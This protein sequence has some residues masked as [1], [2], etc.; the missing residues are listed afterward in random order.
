FFQMLYPARHL[1]IPGH[2]DWTG[3]GQRFAWRMKIFYKDFDM[4]FYTVTEGG[5]GQQYE[6][7]L[8]KMLTTKQ[9]TALGYYPDLIPTTARFIQAQAVQSGL[10]NPIVR[11]DFQSGL[12][13]GPMQYL[14]DPKADATQL[15]VGFFGGVDW[16][17]PYKGE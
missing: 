7:T 10:P 11:V 2:V 6:T 9:Y 16:V 5:N 13:G 1:L 8:T 3:E 14:L 15:N 12:N 4:H 17:L